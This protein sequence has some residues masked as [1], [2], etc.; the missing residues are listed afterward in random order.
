LGAPDDSSTAVQ[1]EYIT[2]CVANTFDLN[3]KT[4]D[5]ITAKLGFMARDQETRTALECG[6]CHHM[7]ITTAEAD[8]MKSDAVRWLG[9]NDLRSPT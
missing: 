7:H 9:G 3:I 4:A 8:P 2:G 5:K 1:A 6:G